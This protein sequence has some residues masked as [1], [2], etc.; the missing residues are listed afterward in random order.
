MKEIL[1]LMDD[2]SAKNGAMNV[3]V[4]L[5]MRAR[6]ASRRSTIVLTSLVKTE[7]AQVFPEISCAHAQ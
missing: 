3:S 7:I 2:V 1:A 5:D 4:K 6:T